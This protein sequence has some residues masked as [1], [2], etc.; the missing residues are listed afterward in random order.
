MLS[1]R[2]DHNQTA[3]QSS[4]DEKPNYRLMASIN[5]HSSTL[6]LPYLYSNINFFIVFTLMLGKNIGVLDVSGN[7]LRSIPGDI[8][9]L[10]ELRGINVSQNSIKCSGPTDYSGLPRE[11]ARLRHLQVTYMYILYYTCDVYRVHCRV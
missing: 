11:L 10:T 3:G 4:E 8:H 2:R 5:I 7:N 9:Q 1:R 6:I